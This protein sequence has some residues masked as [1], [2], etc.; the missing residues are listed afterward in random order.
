[1]HYDAR[2]GAT[3]LL[4]NLKR[5]KYMSDT[6]NNKPLVEA[7]LEV[8]W[9]LV[10]EGG[11]RQRDPRSQ[12]L[13]GQLFEQLKDNFPH[14][15]ELPA[16]QMPDGMTTYT[17]RIQFR[18]VQDGWPL[19][20][21]GPGILTV[22]QTED[23]EWG[24]YLKLCTT[25][26][27]TLFNVYPVNECTLDIIEVSLRYID[28]DKLDDSIIDFMKKLK[29]DFPK[30]GFFQDFEPVDDELL[31]GSLSMT[32]PCRKPKGALQLIYNQGTKDEERALIWE[33][34]VLSRAADAPKCHDDFIKW[35]SEAHTITHEWFMHQIA[36]D[37]L[38][39]Y[40]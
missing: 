24:A 17:P 30:P 34:R 7:I 23:Y 1:M 15:V 4:A 27:Q 13:A 16:S 38:Q 18:A 14:Q 40:K 32:Y 8:K 2:L 11:G 25:V 10:S 28:A 9:A 26:I 6:L 19:M 29:I 33:T 3:I 35:M 22:N 5:Q 20:Q 39:K 36:G 31:A 21:L 12:L 37:L